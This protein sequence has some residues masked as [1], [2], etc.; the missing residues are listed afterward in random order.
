MLHSGY[1][2]VNLIVPPNH[3]QPACICQRIKIPQYCLHWRPAVTE[4]NAVPR[5]C[6]VNHCHSVVYGLRFLELICSIPLTIKCCV[7]GVHSHALPSTAE[8]DY[9]EYD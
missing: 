2:V 6:V 8:W 4:I 3:K 9:K 1:R 5:N 7:I